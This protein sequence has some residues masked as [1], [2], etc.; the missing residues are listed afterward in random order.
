[1]LRV[2]L[3]LLLIAVG[4]TGAVWLADNPGDVV[5]TWQGYRAETSLVVA[6]LAIIALTG[7]LGLVW[8][9]IRSIFR[10]PGLL[11]LASRNRRRA[12]GFTSVTR[13]M[14]AVG[15][16][17][18]VAAR[19]HANE[20]EKMLGGA[21]LVLLLK[22]Q[23]AQ[24]SGDRKGAES[25]FKSMIEDP[26]TRVLGLRGLH[27]EA[28]RRNDDPAALS[29][30]TEASRL[31]P[32]AA[33][34]SQAV[35][36][37]QC[38][39]T[40]WA[41]ARTT[42]DRR[43]AL[44]MIDKAEAKADRAALLTAE[45]LTRAD[46]EPAAAL[47][48]AKEALT[49]KPGLAPAAAIAGRQLARQGDLRRASRLLEAAW[50]VSPHPDIAEVYLD[51]RQG[52]TTHD[53]LARARVLHKF[54]RTSDEAR[55]VVMQAATAAA[56]YALARRMLGELLA[57]QPTARVYL[58]AADLATAEHGDG[59]ETREML[60]RAAR[61]DRDPA[62]CADGL[63]S[64]QWM[65]VS[66]LTG[67]ID[68]FVWTTPPTPL[69]EMRK[70]LQDNPQLQDNPPLQDNPAWVE[71]PTGSVIAAQ[72]EA[73]AYAGTPAQSA[74]DR[75]IDITPATLAPEASTQIPA[76]TTADADK[77]NLSTR[78]D[79]TTSG[80]LRPE[81]EAKAPTP[82]ARLSSMPAQD[83]A[84]LRPRMAV[85]NGLAEQ[86]KPAAARRAPIIAVPPPPDDPG[87]MSEQDDD[88]AH[89]FRLQR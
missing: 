30:A 27:M 25:A 62:W 42:L 57:G 56:E 14:V 66:P 60:A 44:R 5:V 77:G 46:A 84:T 45:A 33:W 26:E 20:A 24:M 71:K 72:P 53:R 29:Y 37:E 9:I 59:G 55:L 58:A 43:A 2:L 83:K 67:R 69:S 47:A 70:P 81:P 82:P 22:A 63:V 61:A 78:Q 12:K 89:R 74:S 79:A 38:T 23:T 41:G 51:V 35:L 36:I 87:P 3:F 85:D 8:T 31:A 17:D 80:Q 15:S 64:Q 10:L 7:T 68:A 34:A 6:L 75:I 73:L 13:G 48:L 54:A 40:D 18:A 88:V 4:A 19:R 1:M 65:P 39:R 32:G 16:G 52:D 86:A 50:K 11:A 49:L 21:P 76:Q 28:R